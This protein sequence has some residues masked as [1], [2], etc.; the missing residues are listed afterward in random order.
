MF[1]LWVGSGIRLWFWLRF[2]FWL[3]LWLW[4]RHALPL[5]RGFKAGL[6]FRTPAV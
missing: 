5:V 2:R 4:Q 6:A 3:W 1:A